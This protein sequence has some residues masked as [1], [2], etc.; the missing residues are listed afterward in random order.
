MP[1]TDRLTTIVTTFHL[2]E[3]Q[4]L[5]HSSFIASPTHI[6]KSNIFLKRTRDIDT[7]EKNNPLPSIAHGL[8]GLTD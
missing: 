7:V 1:D 3:E 5:H 8:Y 6:F 2:W 4:I